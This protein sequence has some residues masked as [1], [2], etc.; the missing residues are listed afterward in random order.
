MKE[1]NLSKCVMFSFWFLYVPKCIFQS[2]IESLAKTKFFHAFP[3]IEFLGG[4][5]KQKKGITYH[6][7]IHAMYIYYTKV[8]LKHSFPSKL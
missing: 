8:K 7:S 6:W 4:A 1:N 2:K 3:L 5:V